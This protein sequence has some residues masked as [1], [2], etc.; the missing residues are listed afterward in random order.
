[1]GDNVHREYNGPAVLL[2]IPSV[3][4][5]VVFLL[6]NTIVLV[7][8]TRTKVTAREYCSSDADNILSRDLALSAVNLVL[9]AGARIMER[10]RDL[11]M[12]RTV[13][14]F[15]LLGSLGEGF[16][17]IY[18]SYGLATTGRCPLDDILYTMTITSTT[19]FCMWSR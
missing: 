9:M 1:M 4:H 15:A 7:V 16:A 18:S 12:Y 17:Q 14:F 5:S 10:Q 11:Y 8:S 3:L 6:P 19:S 2:L 13:L